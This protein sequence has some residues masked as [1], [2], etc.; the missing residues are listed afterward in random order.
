VNRSNFVSLNQS[1]QNHDNGDDQKDV[2]EVAHRVT[3]NQS[4]QPQND[5]NES[6][7]V[8]HKKFRLR[9]FAGGRGASEAT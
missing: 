4:E 2:N 3:R 9:I 8:E 5:Q 7:C 6:E 1:H